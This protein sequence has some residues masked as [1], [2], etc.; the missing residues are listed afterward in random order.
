MP[1]E[2]PFASREAAPEA[3]R[4]LLT[5]R[6]G[7]FVF[8]AETLAVH[9]DVAGKL[10]TLRKD[11]D[12]HKGLKTKYSKF[13][14]IP[15]LDLDE[16]LE[17][18]TLKQQGKP[19]SADEKAEYERKLQKLTTTHGT[20]LKTRDEKLTAYE[21]EL[22]RFK[23]GQPLRRIAL[24]AGVLPEDLELAML[25]TEGKFKL[26]DD[27]KKIV[28]LDDDGDEVATTP[29]EFYEKLYKAQRPK[30]YAAT[31]KYGGGADPNQRSSGGG[32]VVRISSADAR[33]TS[34]YKAARAR[35]EKDGVPLEIVD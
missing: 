12:A 30:F 3:I 31:G 23:L 29:K 9:N 16:L 22:K 7:Q 15:D 1:V 24:E 21:K 17:L 8:E 27:G 13:E 28:M 34:K 2:I 20:E 19:L 33:D 10:K 32:A 26:S 35:A 25:E 14:E 6:D 18:R 5:E 11:L 4:E